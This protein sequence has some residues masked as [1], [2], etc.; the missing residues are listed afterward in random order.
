MIKYRAQIWLSVLTIG[1]LSSLALNRS[2]S[3]IHKVPGQVW[4]K[5]FSDLT[6]RYPWIN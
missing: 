6:M 5:A 1:H 2:L 3:V 4:P